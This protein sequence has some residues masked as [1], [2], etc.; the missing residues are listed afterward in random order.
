[1]PSIRFSR[2]DFAYAGRD[3]VLHDVDLH[4]APGWTGVVGPNGAG[5][6][7]LLRLATGELE[8]SSGLVARDP[9]DA[10]IHVCAQLVADE[11]PLSEG[12]RKIRQLDLAIAA[13]PDIL[14]LDEPTNHLDAGARARVISHLRRFRGIGIV[15]SHDRELLDLLTTVTVRVDGGTAHAYPGSYSTARSLWQAE[16]DA[17]RDAWAVANRERER[18]AKLLADARRTAAATERSTSRSSRMKNARDSDG[19]SVNKTFSAQRAAGSAGA[20]VGRRRRALDDAATTAAHLALTTERGGEIHLRWDPPPKPWLA[21]DPLPIER[22]SR[23]HLAGPNGAGKSTLLR[24]IVAGL[25]LPPERV[26]WLPQET[27]VEEGRALA[28]ELR[29][30]PPAE[31][32]R[33]GQLAAALGLDPSRA[34]GS[35][36]P[37]PGEVRKLALALGLARPLWLVLLDEPTNHL[38]LPA[39]ERLES[40]LADYPG[41]LV[42]ATHDT[43]LATRVTREATTIRDR[44]GRLGRS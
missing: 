11:Q 36:A 21:R 27:S 20:L 24:R 35:G 14:V 28:R 41:A 19:R 30:L 22:T 43:T 33:V 15:V 2:V 6:T 18:A 7:T 38:D 32:G 40:A 3:P 17:R 13:R 5:K 16:A 1:M 29:A 34:L 44:S 39:I 23:I 10:A 12:E 31:R 9:P 37:S 42:I 8:P 26:L 4:F 25:A